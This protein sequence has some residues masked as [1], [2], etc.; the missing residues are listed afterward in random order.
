MYLDFQ[1]E[2][3]ASLL[4]I[5]GFLLADQKFHFIEFKKKID[6]MYCS[7]LLNLCNNYW[8]YVQDVYLYL[9][10]IFLHNSRVY[11]KG[12]DIDPGLFCAISF[13]SRY[14]EKGILNDFPATSAEVCV[15][16]SE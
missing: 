4:I 11:R 6:N 1:M 13:I 16:L 3:C 8:L 7:Q 12:G 5:S 2:Y 14:H 9:Y 15:C 10:L